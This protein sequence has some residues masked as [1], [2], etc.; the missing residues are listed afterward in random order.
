M[1]KLGRFSLRFPRIRGPQ[2]MRRVPLLLAGGEWSARLPVELRRSL[3]RLVGEGVLAN[4][5]DSIVNTYQAVYLLAL[6]ASRTEIG[7]VSS[8]SNIAMP[9]AMLP[10]GRL[11][12]RRHRY[13][14]LVIIPS[15]LGRVLLLGLIVLPYC[16]WRP[17]FIIYVGIGIAILRAFL[18]HLANPAWTA[19]LGQ[20]VPVRWR[21]RY[22]SARNIF[23][24][25]AAFL[26]LL[27]VGRLI[28]QLGT[29][30]GYQLVFGIAVL[31]ALGASY[32]LSGVVEEP[33]AARPRQKEQLISLPQRV[34]A[35]KTFL[36]TSGV[37][38]LWG[39]AV[40]IA[41]PFFIVYLVDEVQASASLVALSSATATLAS[42]PAQRIFGRLIDRKGNGWVKRLTG[43]IIPVVPGLWGFIQQPW[44]AFPLQLVSGFIWAGYN[45]AS[46]NRL[47]EVTPAEDRPIFVAIRQS[48]VGVG[49]A[50]GA[51]LG[52]WLAETQGYRIVFLFSAGGRLLAAIIFALS[53]IP[54]QTWRRLWQGFSRW[55]A[56][57]YRKLSSVVSAALHWCGQGLIGL[58]YKLKQ[59]RGRDG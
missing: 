39:F 17:A 9:L 10:G 47:L 43:L 20:L 14:W 2:W 31:A 18:L 49:M 33:P 59:K 13:K 16:P 11:A 27:G 12:A 22:F 35:E 26:A 37:A 28:D 52:G 53:M 23:M 36:S 19:M 7:L 57:G 46:F 30:L 5:S 58:W 45:L 24:G 4:I 44:Q 21:G 8:L 40:S 15:L 41:T 48:L 32:L 1:K 25:G 34:W 38:F 56:E 51:A 50:V 55:I 42:L 54:V 3:R 6:G 29:P